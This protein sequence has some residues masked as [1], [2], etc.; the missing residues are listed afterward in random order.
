MPRE[1]KIHLLRPDNNEKLGEHMHLTMCGIIT[2]SST[3]DPEVV[4]CKHCSGAYRTN[5]EWYSQVKNKAME[6]RATT[7]EGDLYTRQDL[8][9]GLVRLGWTTSAVRE[10]LDNT[11]LFRNVFLATEQ[12]DPWQLQS[13]GVRVSPGGPRR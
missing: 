13:M 11:N 3:T 6:A 1:L 5:M 8:E 10:V 9:A 12:P 7:G 4:S 2:E